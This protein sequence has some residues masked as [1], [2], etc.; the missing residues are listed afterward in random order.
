MAGEVYDSED[1]SPEEQRI[2]R[3]QAEHLLRT[4]SS[5]R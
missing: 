5:P 1:L 2:L 3:F 4:V